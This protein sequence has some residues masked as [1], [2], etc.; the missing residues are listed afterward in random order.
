MPTS[1]VVNDS[2]EVCYNRS[3][4]QGA[5]HP[6]VIN[7]L[8]SNPRKVISLGRLYVRITLIQIP[9]N[10]LAIILLCRTKKKFRG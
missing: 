2:P 8:E 6:D 5:L 1:C 4:T 3:S 10:I 7:A 9:K